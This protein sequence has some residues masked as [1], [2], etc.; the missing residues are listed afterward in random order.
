MLWLGDSDGLTT[1]DCSLEQGW[2]IDLQMQ[3][4]RNTKAPLQQLIF[5]IVMKFMQQLHSLC[6]QTLLQIKV[7]L[8]TSIKWIPRPNM[9]GLLCSLNLQGGIVERW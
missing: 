4:N 5:Q 3:K 7:N 9:C 2:K 1:I 6:N 8:Q